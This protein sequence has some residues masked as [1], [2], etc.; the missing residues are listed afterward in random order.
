M[1]QACEK[2]MLEVV[3][4]L[5]EEKKVPLFVN[6]YCKPLLRACQFR[7]VEVTLYLLSRND[8]KQW[9]KSPRAEQVNFR[10]LTKNKKCKQ[11]ILFRKEMAYF[12]MFVN[13]PLTL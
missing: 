12:R 4:Y 1:E 11:K 13:F 10:L 8:V 7:S 3:K 2:N 9:L 5:I 6:G